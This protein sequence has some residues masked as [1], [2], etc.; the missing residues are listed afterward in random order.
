MTAKSNKSSLAQIGAHLSVAGGLHLALDEAVR[1]GFD[2]VQ[3]F[4]KNQRQWKAAP[5]SDEQVRLFREARKRTGVGPVT[6][7]ASYLINLAAPDPVNL[8]KST[9]A[10]VDELERCEALGVELLV[11]HPGAHLGEG[12]D[13]GIARIAKTLDEIHARTPGFKT[14]IGLEDT[15]GQG[16]TIGRELGELG[17]IIDGVKSPE[18]LAVCLDTC[19]LFAA[20]YDLRDGAGYERMIAEADRAFGLGRVQCIHT[21]DSVMDVGSRRDRH[22][23]IGLGKLGRRGFELILRDPRLVQAPRILETE[24]GEDEKGREWLAVDGAA[25]RR[26]A[27]P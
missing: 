26:I 16:S 18:R 24:H 7:H 1:L 8:A 5:L 17:R 20:G 10:M 19:H 6:A 27:R 23:H 25:L 15:A 21:N 14:R 11:V 13:A 12:L 4:V 3:L 22:E 2:C 9:D